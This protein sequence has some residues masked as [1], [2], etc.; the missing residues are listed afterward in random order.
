MT[1]MSLLRSHRLLGILALQACLIWGGVL[2]LWILASRPDPA[3]P[4]G[5]V[6]EAP[7]EVAALDTAAKERTAPQ[8]PNWISKPLFEPERRIAV[9]DP[10]PESPP[11]AEV[12]PDLLLTGVVIDGPRRFA[13]LKDQANRESAILAPGDRFKGWRLTDL[14]AE[15][16]SLS[17]GTRSVQLE[18]FADDGRERVGHSFSPAPQRPAS[19]AE[20]GSEQATETPAQASF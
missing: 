10:E 9:A 4:T 18:L 13:V 15:Q 3:A 16:A 17:L 12:A 11:S 2:I 7:T 6:G 19:Q 14:S 20:E 5:T 8:T 1:L